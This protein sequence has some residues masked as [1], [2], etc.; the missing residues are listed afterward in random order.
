MPERWRTKGEFRS[1]SNTS[2]SPANLSRPSRDL[3]E[4]YKTA[5]AVADNVATVGASLAHVHVPGRAAAADELD[6]NDEIEIGM[7][8]HNEEGFGRV[9]TDLPGLVKT[10]LGQLLDQAD[11]DRAFIGIN[12]GDDVALLINNLGGLS[13]LEL[14]AA[15]DEVVKQ[16]GASYGIAPKRV[17]AGTYMSSL[18]G[19]GFSVT[20]LK[21]ADPSWLALV[22]APTEASGWLPAVNPTASTEGPS[23]VQGDAAEEEKPQPSNLKGT[24]P[25]TSPVQVFMSANTSQSTASAPRPP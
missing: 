21:L 11:K 5:A 13:V 22:D 2:C 10:M 12:K 16:L 25:P 15:A 24:F 14:G 23:V 1:V 3:D 6:T 4:V 7:G 19:L 8:I 20:L 17:L 9:K 18:N